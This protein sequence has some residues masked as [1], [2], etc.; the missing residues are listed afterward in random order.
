MEGAKCNNPFVLITLWKLGER[1]LNYSWIF[2]GGGFTRADLTN[3]PNTLVM[4]GK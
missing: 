3:A 4:V 2:Y 1:S